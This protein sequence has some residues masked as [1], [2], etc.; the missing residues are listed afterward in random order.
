MIEV[1]AGA[2]PNFPCDIDLDR[3]TE[4]ELPNPDHFLRTGAGGT[5]LLAIFG[6]GAEPSKIFPALH[7]CS[8]G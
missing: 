8:E 6:A 5:L 7:L 4:P 1:G 3:G 2:E